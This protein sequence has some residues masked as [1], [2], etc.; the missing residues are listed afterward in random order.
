MGQGA[1]PQSGA[2][3]GSRAVA[4]RERCLLLPGPV[5]PGS[6]VGHA[7]CSC[8]ACQQH[9]ALWQG[10]SVWLPR[11]HLA[12]SARTGA[13]ST[14]LARPAASQSH[15]APTM[16]LALPA[17]LLL[18]LCAVAASQ[19]APAPPPTDCFDCPW[20][21]LP[22]DEWTAQ[23]GNESRRRAAGATGGGAAPLAAAAS[24]LAPSTASGLTSTHPETSPQLGCRCLPATAARRCPGGRW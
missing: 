21:D 2:A 8:I 14:A 3:R 5:L 17:A 9:A 1:Q 15:S 13:A 10:D 20:L 7:D 19:A 6:S 16:P 22:L 4:W 12:A 18:A 23:A 11:R 24:A